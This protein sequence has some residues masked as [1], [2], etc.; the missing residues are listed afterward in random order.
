MKRNLKKGD[1][2]VLSRTMRVRGILNN[3]KEN[4]SYKDFTI[5]WG[6]MEIEITGYSK[7]DNNAC[8]GW[9]YTANVEY[10]G[11]VYHVECIPQ[12]RLSTV[13]LYNESKKMKKL[14]EELEQ[15]KKNK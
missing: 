9:V 10:K 11:E 5:K 1:I 6:V 14:L 12:N 8:G 13:E 2:T 7:A 15:T 3:N 4:E